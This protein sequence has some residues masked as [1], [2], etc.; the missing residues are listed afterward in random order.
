MFQFI[1]G[2]LNDIIENIDDR[3]GRPYWM[4]KKEDGLWCIYKDKITEA[5]Y[6]KYN[7]EKHGDGKT[8]PCKKCLAEQYRMN[9]GWAQFCEEHAPTL[10]MDCTPEEYEEKYGI[11][12]SQIQS[13]QT[14]IKIEHK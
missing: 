4:Y 3:N 13:E 9:T 2:F 8:Y 1:K 7:Q 14:N 10:L 5:D 6:I 12:L 11:S